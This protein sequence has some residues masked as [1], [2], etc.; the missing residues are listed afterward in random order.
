MSISSINL[1]KIIIF[2][3]PSEES[4]YLGKIVRG[5]MVFKMLQGF[6]FNQA[7]LGMSSYRN[8]R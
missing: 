7:T 3:E 5:S 6:E 8:E 4:R 1:F 2:R